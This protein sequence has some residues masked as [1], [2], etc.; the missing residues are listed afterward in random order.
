MIQKNKTSIFWTPIFFVLTAVLALSLAA[1][2]GGEQLLLAEYNRDFEAE[3]FLAEL[4]SESSEWQSLAE[5]AV[6]T[7]LFDGRLATFVP[8]TNRI[9]LWYVDRNDLRVEQMEIGDDAPTELYEGNAADRVFGSISNDPFIVFLT[10]TEDFSEFSCYASVDGAEAARLAKGSICV[11][12][13]NG[14]VLQER[15]ADELSL[16]LYSLDGEDETVILDEV[17]DVLE[18][19]W[20]DDLSWFTYVELDRGD[21][22]AYIIEPGDEEATAVGDEFEIIEDVGFIA[23][24]ETIYLIGK[25]DEDDDELGLFINAA[26]DPVLE[27]EIIRFA[28]RSEDNRYIY[29]TTESTREELFFVYDVRGES[30]TEVADGDFISTLG[31]YGERL[32]LA[33][34]DNDDTAL[35]SVN[36]DGTEL[37]ELYSDDEYE[38]IEVNVDEANGR[39]YLTLRDEDGLLSL[40]VTSLDEENGYFLLEEWAA[41]NLMNASDDTA[42]FA[43]QEDEGDDWILYAIPVEE[44]ADEVELDDDAENGFQGAYLTSNGR[45]VL[46][47]AIGDDITEAEVRQAQLDGEEGAETLFKDVVLLDVSWEGASNL[48]SVR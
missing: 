42:V 29:F 24:D 26:G 47:T 4:G 17:E 33:V 35:I 43:A 32:L 38:P 8:E 39:V 11:A 45:S 7:S 40:Y 14:V 23:D 21:G 6:S 41:L 13:E 27:E 46:Y 22:Q 10:E 9:V 28:G 15:D 36:V 48:E 44:G 37:V 31:L 19:S 1:C 3:I 12:S 18:V 5:D 30:A 16:T 34:G 2:S 25:P 20:N